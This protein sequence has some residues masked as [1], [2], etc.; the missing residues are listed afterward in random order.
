MPL[1]VGLMFKK[2]KHLKQVYLL[3]YKQQVAQLVVQEIVEFILLQ[4]Q[5][6]LQFVV[7][8]LLLQITQ[9]LI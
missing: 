6:L 2:L 1:K 8:Q 9:F 4:D 7:F 3:L 5:E